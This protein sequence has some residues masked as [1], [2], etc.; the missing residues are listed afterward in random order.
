MITSDL[1]DSILEYAF[2]GKLTKQLSS[3]SNIDEYYNRIASKRNELIKNKKVKKLKTINNEFYPFN[4]PNNWKWVNLQEIVNVRSAVRVHQSDWKK[5]GVPFYRAREVVKL[6][7]EGFVDNE[8]FIS[9]EL[10]NKFKLQSGVPQENDLLVSGVGTIGK[11]YV[12]KSNDKFYYKDASVIC[13]ENFFGINPFY[14]KYML[15]APFMVKQ[16]NKDAMGTT[17]ATLTMDRAYGFLVPLAPI[18]EQQRIVEKLDRLFL[19]LDETDLIE[20][21][22][23]N[24]KKTIS[25]DLKYSILDVAFKGLL[26][27]NDGSLKKVIESSYLCEPFSIPD[28]WSWVK[29]DDVLDIQTGLGYKKTDQCDSSKGEIRVLRGGNINNNYQYELKND[30]VYVRGIKKYT[31]LKIGDILTPSVTSMEQM[32]KVAYIDKELS[33]ITAGGF[34]YIIRSKNYDVL[35]PKFALYFISS[36]F[37][38]EMCMPNIH[39]SGQAFFNLKKSGLIEQPIPIPPIEEQKRIVDKIEKLLPLCKDMES[40]I[41]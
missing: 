23:I 8:L 31:E 5:S 22:L 40:L 30:D 39:K 18:E 10:Y 28:N 24:L 32:G 16:I 15:Q 3:D 14:L 20:K 6:S 12:V 9:E 26:I 2:S 33:G 17:V 27:K 29:I 37:H 34:V 41:D 35:N 38:K 25:S 4:L 19:I 21:D 13:F 11:A 7:N 36:K 1:K